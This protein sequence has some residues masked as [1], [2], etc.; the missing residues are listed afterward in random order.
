MMA[1]SLLDFNCGGV[2]LRGLHSRP[3]KKAEAD[4]EERM[5]SMARGREGREKVS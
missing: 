4:Y 2:R 3:A 5:A 1:R